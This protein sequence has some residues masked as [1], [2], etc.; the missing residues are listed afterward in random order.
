[1]YVSTFPLGLVAGLPTIVPG[2]LRLLIKRGDLE[3]IRGCL[4]FLAVFRV[5]KVPS[6][7]KLETITAPFTGISSSIPNLELA[8]VFKML[9]HSQFKMKDSLKFLRLNTAGP[10]GNPSVLSLHLDVEAW[11][12]SPLRPSLEQFITLLE[13]PNSPFL[14]LLQRE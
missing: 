14:A 3:T 9:G 6:V 2:N 7:L 8:Q 13:G 4:A 10:N 1:M 11:R 5:L 12:V